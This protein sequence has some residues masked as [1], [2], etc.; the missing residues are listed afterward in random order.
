MVL[1]YVADIFS[2]L[3]GAWGKTCVGRDIFIWNPTVAGL[4]TFATILCIKCGAEYSIVPLAIS[5]N[6]GFFLANMYMIAGAQLKLTV[7]RYVAVEEQSE[8]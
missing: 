2:P 3:V 1:A 7:H 5:F 8:L 4:T 6:A